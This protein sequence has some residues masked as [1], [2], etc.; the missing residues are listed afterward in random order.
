MSQASLARDVIPPDRPIR[1]RSPILV[2]PTPG[3]AREELTRRADYASQILYMARLAKGRPSR[4]WPAWEPEEV[5]AVA[6][7]LNDNEALRDMGLHMVEAV[8]AVSV[9]MGIS[10]M[11]A[12]M[13]RAMEG[14]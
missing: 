9:D 5:L 7:V 14:S 2:E 1:G 4:A 13:L 6:V 3:V 10:E 12:V 11:R 8:L